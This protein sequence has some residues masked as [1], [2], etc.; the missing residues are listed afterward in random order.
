M[1]FRFMLDFEDRFNRKGWLQTD[2]PFEIG[3]TFSIFTEGGKTY[4][5][6]PRP[7]LQNKRGA[8]V[9]GFDFQMFPVHGIPK[10]ERP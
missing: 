9:M 6:F 1:A 4:I 8:G 5:A 10:E 2:F 3:D 7:H